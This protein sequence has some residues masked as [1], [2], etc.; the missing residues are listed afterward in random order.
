MVSKV[1]GSFTNFEGTLQVADDLF[2]SSVEVSIDLSSI[3]TREESRDNHLRSADFFDVE[4]H[5]TGTYR[6]TGI[7]PN[8]EDYIIEGDLTLHGVTRAVPLAVEFNGAHPDMAGGTRAGFSATAQISRKDF[9]IDLS[10]PL[11][12]GGVVIGDTIQITLEIEA[13]LQ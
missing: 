12:G 10:M 4:N 8:G 3:N 13:V 11:E 2:A 6:S 5:P 9:G 1:R 7:R